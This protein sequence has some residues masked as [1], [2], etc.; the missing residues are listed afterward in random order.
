MHRCLA[1]P[2]ITELILSQLDDGYS[3]SRNPR[4]DLAKRDLAALARTSKGFQGPALDILWRKQDRLTNILKCLPPNLWEEMVGPEPGGP[5]QLRLTGTVQT[6]DWERPLMYARRIRE[7]ALTLQDIYQAFPDACILDAISCSLPQEL[8]CPNLRRIRWHPKKEFLFPY[9]RLFLG[10]KITAADLTLPTT[11]APNITLLPT[12]ELRYPELK[13]LSI[14][15]PSECPLLCRT[16]SMVAVDLQR[17]EI[18]TFDT[19]DRAALQHLSQLPQLRSLTLQI[20]E[21]NDL[22]PPSLS[23]TTAPPH[24]HPFPAL[25]D[26]HFESTTVEFTTEFINMLSDCRLD[27]VIM[28]TKV[29]ATTMDTSRLYTSL[30]SHLSHIALQSL[31]IDGDDLTTSQPATITNYLISG[32]ALAPLFCFLNLTT[33]VLRPPVGFNIDDATAWD[34]A[35]AWPKLKSLALEAASG[36][37][38]PTSM[39]LVGLR[40]F[41]THCKDLTYLTITFDAS[42]VPPFDHSPEAMISHHR[43]RTLGVSASPISDAPDVARLISDLFPS[44][45][46]IITLTESRGIED[47]MDE[48]IP[49]AWACHTQW[50]HVEVL[51]PIMAGIRREE[52]QRAGVSNQ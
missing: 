52:R 6:A 28:N 5:L 41:A 36:V 4:R 27:S 47:E 23:L 44:V 13:E 38:H 33:L 34:I 19:L 45:V 35:R 25:H 39:T 46:Q 14:E 21:V 8:L 1:I 10:P 11:S 9:I 30:A 31:W 37:H 51:V 43:L 15:G 48:D 32:H 7:L 42:T 2:E 29:L 50:K 49:E 18:L 26:V 20:P 3:F 40:A 12:L 17:I 24:H 22:G 16:S